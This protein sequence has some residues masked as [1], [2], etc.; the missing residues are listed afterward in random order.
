MIQ[1]F[2]ITRAPEAKGITA[3]NLK[4]LLEHFRRDTEWA[5][6][7]YEKDDQLAELAARD[8]EIAQLKA[9]RDDLLE[10]LKTEYV[11]EETMECPMC[12]CAFVRVP[13][14]NLQAAYIAAKA[15]IDRLKS[16]LARLR[17]VKYSFV[18]YA[19]AGTTGKIDKS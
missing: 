3:L 4:Q 6:M 16:E 1:R 11:P 8:V 14:L 15:E 18:E 7:E 5:V 19:N 12:D 2:L 10:G 17:K 9:E 13:P